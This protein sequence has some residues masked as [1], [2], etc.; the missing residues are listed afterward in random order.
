MSESRT[1]DATNPGRG[2]NHVIRNA[3]Q[4]DIALLARMSAI[5]FPATWPYNTPTW[6]RR[7][8]WKHVLCSA[9]AETFICEVG[10]RPAGFAIG[11]LWLRVLAA[12]LRPRCGFGLISRRRRRHSDDAR[13]VRLGFA[14]S[15]PASNRV[16]LATAGVLPAFRRR[17]IAREL[18]D[19]RERRALA[20]GKSLAWAAVESGNVAAELLLARCQYRMVGTIVENRFV[21]SVWEKH[22]CL[23]SSVARDSGLTPGAPD[24]QDQRRGVGDTVTTSHRTA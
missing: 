18:N 22:L 16:Y 21:G 23:G 8:F 11:S 24:L 13:S 20:L 3:D 5:C 6:Y 9:C 4:R 2:Q 7:R 15:K 1:T 14:L 12:A 10:G 19:H 17:A